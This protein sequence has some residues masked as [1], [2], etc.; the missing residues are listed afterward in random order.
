MVGVPMEGAVGAGNN[1]GGEGNPQQLMQQFLAGVGRGMRQHRIIN[2]RI[3]LRHRN[4]SLRRLMPNLIKSIYASE[5]RECPICY[6]D[7]KSGDTVLSLF[8]FHLFHAECIE[9]CLETSTKCPVCSLDLL[10]FIYGKIREGS[11]IRRN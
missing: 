4:E 1:E 6:D 8:C 10:E 7:I 3:N 5:S 11:Y 2:M 9:C